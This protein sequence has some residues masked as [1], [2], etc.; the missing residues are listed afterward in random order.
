MCAFVYFFFSY[1][2]YSFLAFVVNALLCKRSDSDFNFF[3][4]CLYAEAL[5]EFFF[6]LFIF[7]H[8]I[9]IL[10]S[11]I[12]CFWFL[13]GWY[14][15]FF[16]WIDEH[17]NYL[18]PFCSHEKCSG[19]CHWLKKSH[20]QITCH[21]DVLVADVFIVSAFWALWFCTYFFRIFLMF[22]SLL[23][24]LEFFFF[25]FISFFGIYLSA[26]YTF[27]SVHTAHVFMY[28]LRRARYWSSL[29]HVHVE[30]AISHIMSVERHWINATCFHSVFSFSDCD[31]GVVQS[32]HFFFR[33]CLV[34][35]CCC[36]S[37]RIVRSRMEKTKRYT[38][39]HTRQQQ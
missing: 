1:G 29:Y 22:L 8:S 19:H 35:C 16:A 17:R 7:K 28:A 6:C 15:C 38:H 24:V 5:R 39:T 11:V 18:L 20:N 2:F 9:A 36:F 31:F 30:H 13:F 32:T 23:L 14:W 37:S 3:I 34:S 4:L 10:F 12:C 33:V 21:I 26:F 25:L 27:Y